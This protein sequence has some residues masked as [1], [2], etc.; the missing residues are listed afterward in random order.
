MIK[1]KEIKNDK[2]IYEILTNI[3]KKNDDYFLDHGLNHALTVVGIIEDLMVKSK[4]SIEDIEVAKIAAYVHDLGCLTGREDHNKKSYEIVKKYLEVKYNK[5][6]NRKTIEKICKAVIEHNDININSRISA[7]LVLADKLHFNKQRLLELGKKDPI[8]SEIKK[9]NKL[10]YKIFNNLIE[11]NFI[12]N[13]KLADDFFDNFK[14]TIILTYFA[15]KYLKFNIIYKLDNKCVD[16]D[17]LIKKVD[18]KH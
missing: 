16:F 2:N 7:Y 1:F 9:I 5:S 12:L 4:C 15:A 18:I 6:D 13:D 11:L 14:R 3:N 17:Y 10:D 8:H